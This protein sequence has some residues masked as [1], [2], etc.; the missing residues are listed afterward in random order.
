[1]FSSHALSFQ[2]LSVLYFKEQY[3][4]IYQSY[5]GCEE[6][7]CCCGI[8]LKHNLKPGLNRTRLK[9]KR[10]V[11][12][13]PTRV[14]RLPPR[15]RLRSSSTIRATTEQLRLGA[16]VWPVGSQ[17]SVQ[18]SVFAWPACPC[19]FPAV[20]QLS[21][22]QHLSSCLCVAALFMVLKATEERTC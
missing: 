22:E 1:M 8:I 13:C 17:R 14:W 16:T 9:L 5:F 21:V 10:R 15:Q 11:I 2:I 3:I 12:P 4:L 19:L 18:M 20:M 7:K 6:P